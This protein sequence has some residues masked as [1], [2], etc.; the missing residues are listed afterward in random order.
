MKNKPYNIEDGARALLKKILGTKEDSHVDNTW[1][2]AH[3]GDRFEYE[4]DAQ[5]VIDTLP[6]IFLKKN[7]EPQEGDIGVN[8]H[9]DAFNFATDGKNACWFNAFEDAG[10]YDDITIIYRDGTPVV[11]QE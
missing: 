3:P 9:G 1:R 6:I 8:Q 4:M 11:P 10:H 2:E 5:A 7:A